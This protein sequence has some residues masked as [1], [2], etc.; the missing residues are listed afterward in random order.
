[1]AADPVS[2]VIVPAADERMIREVR[3]LFEEYARSLGVDL[4]F[5]GLAEELAGLPGAYA[6]PLGRLLLARDGATP[7]G[8]VAV[9][10]LEPGV[11]EMKR[12]YVGPSFR[13]SGLGR[14]LAEAAVREARAAGY[15]HMRLDTLP[16]MRSAR[17]LYRALGFRPIA[18][19]RHNPLPG[20]EFL[21]LDLL[22]PRG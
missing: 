11:C 12:L 10:P 8:C 6:P 5:Q 21:E 19:Y 2:I 7:A 16:A 17:A 22:E 13:G 20:A 15:H 14:R 9:R 1:M 4:G 18:P 3:A